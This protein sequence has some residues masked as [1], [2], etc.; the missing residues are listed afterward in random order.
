MNFNSPFVALEGFEP[1]QAESESDVLP[2]HHK[3]I[4]YHAYYRACG[5]NGCKVKQDF[6]IV[7]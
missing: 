3:A 4:V 2:L 1:S 5:F 6:L 7:Q